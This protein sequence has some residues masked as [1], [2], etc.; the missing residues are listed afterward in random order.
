MART[1]L[2]KFIIDANISNLD[3]LVDDFAKTDEKFA[4][5]F[6]NRSADVDSLSGDKLEAYRIWTGA[7]KDYHSRHRLYVSAKEV[8]IV[9]SIA[10]EVD[11][12]DAPEQVDSVSSALEFSQRIESLSSTVFSDQGKIQQ[13]QDENQSLRNQ[14]EILKKKEAEYDLAVK[15]D[16]VHDI[17]TGVS[18]EQYDI[19]LQENSRIQNKNSELAN[20]VDILIKEK[21]LLQSEIKKLKQENEEQSQHVSALEARVTTAE[22]NSMQYKNDAIKL[23]K[24]IEIQAKEFLKEKD[25]IVQLSAEKEEQ[26]R[27]ENKETQVKLADVS[28]KLTLSQET[29][30][31]LESIK[32]ELSDNLMMYASMLPEEFFEVSSISPDNYKDVA[33]RS[34]FFSFLAVVMHSPMEDENFLFRFNIFD[35]ELFKSYKN[36]PEVLNELREKFQNYF[37]K[38]LENHQVKWNML[39]DAYNDEIHITDDSKGNSVVLVESALITGTYS[40][41]ASV[42]TSI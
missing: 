9:S 37:N 32:R 4:I 2:T 15:E 34:V 10:D 31:R 35:R 12:L 7:L 13:L 39:G 24:Q 27:K 28:E 30:S 17:S 23:Q 21:A 16:T 22:N 40:Q 25:E 5:A 3:R 14:I 8:S 19:L 20:N 6:V 33:R 26:L 42:R 36:T 11:A 18:Q 1:P 38:H 29:I 41:R